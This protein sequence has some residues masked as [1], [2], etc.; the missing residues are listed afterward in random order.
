[1]A[2]QGLSLNGGHPKRDLR[3]LQVFLQNTYTD[4]G[5]CRFWLKLY[6]YAG[7]RFFFAVDSVFVMFYEDLEL[8]S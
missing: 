7:N 5:K 6:T 1:M 4:S 3:L 2:L 8:C